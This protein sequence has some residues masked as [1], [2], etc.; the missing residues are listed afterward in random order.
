MRKG[1]L[2]RERHQQKPDF[3]AFK[4]IIKK[5]FPEYTE[6]ENPANWKWGYI[7]MKRDNREKVLEL[8]KDFKELDSTG[9]LFRKF[10]FENDMEYC[11]K[12]IHTYLQ[13]FR[14]SCEGT[15]NEV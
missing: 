15:L 9:H 8:M 10:D 6:A 3:I 5:V 4:K 1:I 14:K 12:R 2:K 13:A 7:N 11:D